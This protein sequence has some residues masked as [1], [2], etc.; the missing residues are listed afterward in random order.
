MHQARD[1]LIRLYFDMGVPYKDIAYILTVNHGTV[2]SVRHI[3]RILRGMTLSRRR[4]YSTLSDIVDFILGQLQTSGQLHGYRWMYEKAY[5]HG[6]KARK[7]DVRAI[8]QV[9]DVQGTEQRRKR[10]LI[11]RTYVS[12]GPNYIWHFDSYD[13]LKPY[14]ICVNGCVDGFSRKVVWMNVYH[15]S[16]D[17]KLIGGYF[18]DAVESLGGGPRVVRGDMGTENG[19]VREMQRF[20]RRNHE[21]AMGGELS[22]LEG[23]STANQRIEYWWNFLRRECTDFWICL[24]RRLGENVYNA[25]FLDM[26]LIRFCFLHLVQVRV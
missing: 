16:S 17:P 13:K 24:F 5:L 8:L 20:L 18:M 1:S 2:I 14:G 12:K 26:N 11:R 6:L 15:N 7:D 23:R 22:Y 10:R 9:L 4:N 21:D 25:G 19:H 3:K